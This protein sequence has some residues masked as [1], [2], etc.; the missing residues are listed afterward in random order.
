MQPFGMWEACLKPS[1]GRATH[2]RVCR[3]GIALAYLGKAATET[4]STTPSDDMT[5]AC[6]HWGA[7]QQAYPPRARLIERKPDLKHLL[8]R[9]AANHF[10]QPGWT[11][12]G[13]GFFKG[14]KHARNMSMSFLSEPNALKGIVEKR[15]H[16]TTTSW[17]LRMATTIGYQYFSGGGLR[18][19]LTG[20]PLKAFRN[21]RSQLVFTSNYRYD[22]APYNVGNY[23]RTLK[24]KSVF[25][26]NHRCPLKCAVRHKSDVLYLR[27]TGSAR[28]T[29]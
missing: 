11:L 19:K 3:T 13:G 8:N 7:G 10:Y 26:R 1:L 28:D 4:S 25:S 18:I 6:C 2:S 29:P 22:L 27:I 17:R 20:P 12:V 14:R 9:P 15:F 24:G 5:F 21:I 23:R 16:P